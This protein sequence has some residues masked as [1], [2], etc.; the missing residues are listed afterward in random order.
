[1]NHLVQGSAVFYKVQ[2]EILIHVAEII[3]DILGP[4]SPFTPLKDPSSGIE[5]VNNQGLVL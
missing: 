3:T 5:I 1:M 4:D 2:Q